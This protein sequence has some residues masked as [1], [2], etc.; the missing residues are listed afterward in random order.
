[1]KKYETLKVIV[2]LQAVSM[3]ALA[4]FTIWSLWPSSKYEQTKNHSSLIQ[5]SSKAN[6]ADEVVAVIAD[7]NITRQQLIDELLKHYGDQT[8]EQMLEHY[9][10]QLATEEYQIIVT[11]QEIEEAIQEQAAGYESVEQYMQVMNEQ[12]GLSSAQVYMKVKDELLLEQIAIKDIEVTEQ[13]KQQFIDEHEELLQDKALLGISWIVVDTI[14]KAN[15][16]LQLLAEG[17]SFEELAK[18]HSIDSFTAANG[19]KLGLIEQGDPFYTK[20]ML[21]LASTLQVGD[22]AGPI[23]VDA[24]YCIFYLTDKQMANGRNEEQIE[25]Y[26]YKHVALSKAE[27]LPTVLSQLLNQY[28]SKIK[29]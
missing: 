24:G 2:I 6:A 26:V 20:E 1:M 28:E 10:I 23:Q 4:G 8:L 16:L 11:E 18:I 17:E 13:E 14:E 9:A 22:I 5:D 25:R 7:R 12:L 27:P 15:Q 29:K 21:E 3:I 19:G